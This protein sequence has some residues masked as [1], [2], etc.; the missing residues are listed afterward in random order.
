MY[1]VKKW[2]EDNKVTKAALARL[3]GISKAQYGRI[4]KGQYKLKH[5]YA[6]ILEEFTGISRYELR[7]DIYGSS[8]PSAERREPKPFWSR[9]LR[10]G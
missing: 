2:R 1:Q 9:L 8:P 4:E 7:P 5:E 10:T 3:L 6:L